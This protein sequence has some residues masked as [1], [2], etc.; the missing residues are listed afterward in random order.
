MPCLD[1][2]TMARVLFQQ[3]IMLFHGALPPLVLTISRMAFHNMQSE[4]DKW[5]NLFL[6]MGKILWQS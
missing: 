5:V 1:Q 4:N 2:A 3:A 6:A